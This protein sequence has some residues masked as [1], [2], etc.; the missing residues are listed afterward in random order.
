MPQLTYIKEYFAHK[1][2]S[3]ED[4]ISFHTM[5]MQHLGRTIQWLC[6]EEF[7]KLF[8]EKEKYSRRLSS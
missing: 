7:R 8:E 6:K 3:S 2:T 5:I 4:H 1:D